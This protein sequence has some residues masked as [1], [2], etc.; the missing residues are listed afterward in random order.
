M[1]H[2]LEKLVA[3]G[4]PV[5]VGVSRKSMITSAVHVDKGD[6]LPATT[7]LHWELLRKGADILRVHDVYEARQVLE[8]Y[9]F[10]EEQIQEQ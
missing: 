10:Y 4:Y 2:G 7:A 1:I 5:L 3:L 6:C 9:N 8:M